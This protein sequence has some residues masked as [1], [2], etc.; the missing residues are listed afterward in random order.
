MS[1]RVCR[2]RRLF[3]CSS[4]RPKYCRPLTLNVPPLSPNAFSVSICNV[5][6]VSPFASKPCWT[7]PLRLPNVSMFSRMVSVIAVIAERW[8]KPAHVAE[9]VL[10]LPRRAEESERRAA[11]GVA[12]ATPG[13]VAASGAGADLLRGMRPSPRPVGRAE[14]NLPWAAQAKQAVASPNAIPIATRRRMLA[15]TTREPGR[16]RKEDAIPNPGPA[17]VRAVA[18]ATSSGRPDV[19]EGVRGESG[20][21]QN[22]RMT[23]GPTQS[24]RQGAS[25]SAS[26]PAGRRKMRGLK[27]DIVFAGGASCALCHR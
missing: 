8:P 20:P 19:K 3:T 4:R 9:Q 13:G 16:M 26:P 10:I 5:T 6:V 23:A 17:A 15:G 2:T 1:V 27:R 11:L 21:F 24:F 18:N 25:P 12:V 14:L 7:P 22:Y